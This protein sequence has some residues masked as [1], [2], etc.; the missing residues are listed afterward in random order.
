LFLHELTD[1]S[2]LEFVLFSNLE[3]HDTVELGRGIILAPCFTGADERHVDEAVSVA[4]A[5]MRRRSRFVYDGWA[6]ITEWSD[7]TVAQSVRQIDEAMLVFSL[8][9]EN[10]FEW[11]A[12]YRVDPEQK[13]TYQ[14]DDDVIQNL[15]EA[16]R[17]MDS[18]DPS[19]RTAIL[20]SLSWLSQGFR[21]SDPAARLV[22]FFLAVESLATYI[23][24]EAENTSLA[25]L[26]AERLTRSEKRAKQ[27]ECIAQTLGD[28]TLSRHVAVERAYLE[29]LQGV[30]RRLRSHVSRVTVEQPELSNTL[31]GDSLG[32]QS[33]YALR[34]FIA[35]GSA[36]AL[37]W[38]HTESIRR[39]LYDA[40]VAARDYIWCILRRSLDLA[41]IGGRVKGSLS[42]PLTHAIASSPHM[43][44]GPTH[45]AVIYA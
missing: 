27:N 26:G 22:F 3:F 25:S 34:N 30:G 6:P 28:A 1:C 43:F 31:F 13:P 2:G 38:K 24:I 12:K 23:E 17:S 42:F 19:D 21:A 15:G 35:H 8:R 36:N 33:L 16:A 41:R 20:R 5:E 40:E 14:L 29:C 39:R 37:D 44:V 10:R 18:M 32:Q 7:D 4:T 9:T 45:M 11:E